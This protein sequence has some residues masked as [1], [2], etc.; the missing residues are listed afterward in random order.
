MI[1]PRNKQ[2]QTQAEQF[3][4]SQPLVKEEYELRMGSQ[5]FPEYFPYKGI[6]VI[7]FI[8]VWGQSYY[9]LQVFPF[10]SLFS[11]HSFNAGPRLGGW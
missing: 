7:W 1:L 3:T 10:A 6:I 9:K 8:G 11:T 2:D 4:Q 5:V